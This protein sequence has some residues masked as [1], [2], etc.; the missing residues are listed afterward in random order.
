MNSNKQ[1]PAIRFKG[2]TDAWEQSEL[3]TLTTWDKKF[4]EVEE[5]KQPRIIKYPYVL[6]DKLNSLEDNGGKVLLLSTGTYV[7]FTT[8]EKA[9]LNLCEGEVVA[10]PWGG[11][12]NIKYWS[13]KFVT[14]DNRIATSNDIQ[15]LRNKFIYYWM[16]NQISNID[17]IYRGASIKHPSMNDIL[18]M[19][20]QYPQISEQ[21]KI[22]TTL[23]NIDSIITLHHRKYEKLQHIKKALLEKMFPKAGA[24]TPEIRFKGFNDAWEQRELQTIYG[25][26]RNA[27]VGTATPYYV[28]NGNFY[29]ESNNIKDGQINRNTEVFINDEFYLKQKE[30][31]LKTGDMVMVQSGHVGHSAVI[32]HNLNNSAAHALIMFAEPKVQVNPYYLNYQ[33]QTLGFKKAIESITTGNTIKHILSSDMKEFQVLFTCIGEQNKIGEIFMKLDS[34]INLHQ[35]KH[36]KLQHIKKALLQNMFV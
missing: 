3:W 25:K 13:G 12:P 16:N 24:N 4:N 19:K 27:F 18:S 15:K 10:I 36:E 22:S 33:Y 26:I 34:L 20:I 5:E 31:W 29:L 7:G 17:K 23:T 8:E 6:A 32:P 30:N 1:T 2:F 9:G 35:R 21:D 28:E 11:T 14:A